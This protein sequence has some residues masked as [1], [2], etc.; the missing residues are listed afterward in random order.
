MWTI[1]SG[2]LG[3]AGFLLSVIN[4]IY[5]YSTR[6]RKVKICIKRYH[7]SKCGDYDIVAVLYRFENLSQLNIS[8]SDAQLVIDDNYYDLDN[9]IHEVKLSYHRIRDKI[10]NQK[11]EYNV[12]LPVNLLPLS[13]HGGFLVFAIPRGT[14]SNGNTTLTLKIWTSRGNPFQRTFVLGEDQVC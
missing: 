11:A 12:M 1:I 7:V 9:Q 8:F 2:V 5:A 3:I 10:I 6:E 4:A 13:S 14:L